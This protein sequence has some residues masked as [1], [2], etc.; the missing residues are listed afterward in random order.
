MD[1][2]GTWVCHSMSLHLQRPRALLLST[3]CIWV[4]VEN[5]MM[6]TLGSSPKRFWEAVLIAP[7]KVQGQHGMHMLRFTQHMACKS[8]RALIIYLSFIRK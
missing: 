2:A 3:L 7:G 6:I 8:V 5:G 4:T 1:L